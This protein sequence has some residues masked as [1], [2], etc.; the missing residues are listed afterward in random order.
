MHNSVVQ[1]SFS[2]G[3]WAALAVLCANWI[4]PISVHWLANVASTI[5]LLGAAI[6]VFRTFRER[7]L[8]AWISGWGVYLL[9]RVSSEA[10]FGKTPGIGVGL[11]Q[12]A[13]VTSV[14]LFSA[15]V[16]F[17]LE[18]RRFVAPTLAIGALFAALAA[19]RPLW[20]ADSAITLIVIQVLYRLMTFSV[21]GTIAVYSRGRRE[22]G[23]WLLAAM[24]VLLHM[25]V[26]T[27]THGFPA[28]DEVIEVLLGLAML[29]IVLDDSR[30]RARRL[31]ISSHITDVAARAPNV[32]AL[33]ES[34]LEEMRKLVRAR[35]ATFRLLQGNELA[36]V[37][38]IGASE[39]F[40]RSWSRPGSTSDF[41]C[42]MLQIGQPIV[43]RRNKIQGAIQQAFIEQHIVYAIVVPVRGNSS[44]IGTLSFGDSRVR[45]YR[46]DE[47]QFLSVLAKQL[48]IAIEN[49]HLIEQI[50]NSQREWAT[51]FDA[52]PDP[53]LVHDRE[54][55][56]MRANQALLERLAR[57][58]TA[59]IGR[60]C[61]EVLP[62]AAEWKQCP[63][64]DLAR[65]VADAPDPCFG[66]FSLV[67]TSRP[68]N[69]DAE[70]VGIIHIIR[71]TTESHAAEER[72]RSL[73]EQVQEG[74]FVSTPDGRVLEC[75]DA[76]VRMFG[77][78]S[79]EEILAAEIARRFYVN[80]EDRY[81]FLR[82]MSEQG[83]VRNFEVRLRK[84]DGTPITLL[85]NSFAVRS[86]TGEIECYRGVLLDISE[87]KRAEDE[88]RRHNREL[89][90]LNTI[91]V[92][93]NQSL[94]LDEI[95]N[96]A[97]RQ[98]I[99]L[100]SA[101]TG[102]IYALQA[103]RK[104]MRRCAT[105]GHRSQVA[106][107]LTELVVEE[108][109][110]EEVLR[111][112]TELVSQKDIGRIPERY[113]TFIEQEGLQSWAWVVMWAN[114]R[115]VGLLAISS[116]SAEHFSATDEKLVVAIARHLANSIEKVRLYDDVCRAYDDLRRTQEQLLQ[117]EKMSAIGQLISGVAHEL[118]NPLTAI[119]G[120]AQLLELEQ[121]DDK[122]R[123]YVDKV[124]KQA[125][126]T[127]RVVQNLL[128]FARQ[129]K[130]EKRVVQLQMV[131]EEAL[132]LRDYDLGLHNIEI[133]RDFSEVPPVFADAHQLEQVF[134]NIINNAVDAIL[135][136]CRGGTLRV[137][138]A[139]LG[140]HVLIRFHDSGPGIKE[141]NRVFDPFYTTKAVG[142]GTGLGLSICYGIVKEH[143]GDIRAHNHAGGG[144]VVEIVLPAAS[145]EQAQAA[146]MR[147]SIGTVPM[148][149]RILIID[150]EQAVVGFEREVL[151]GAGAEVI[152]ASGGE[153][154]ILQLREGAFDAIMVDSC[155]PGGW[156][157]MDIYD[158]LKKNRPGAEKR[159]VLTVSN[160]R[161]PSVQQFLEETKVDYLAKPFEVSEL[162]AVTRR[163]IQ[164]GKEL[165]T[166]ALP[167]L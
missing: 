147:P 163:I 160:L 102:A 116:R 125:Q 23:P 103:D 164:R 46:P 15:A 10:G 122:C 78:S 41:A 25:D 71:D 104:T 97:L 38:A 155:M 100:L 12:A 143:G 138:M 30:A 51:T 45:S 146:D 20:L 79:R 73:F 133:V 9:Y 166:T 69:G 127:Q 80:P 106:E 75:N 48:G 87:Q 44:V 83:Y 64:C 5:I 39:E 16:W 165:S 118:N 62:H 14:T 161:D 141:V 17:Y 144:A 111:T 114:D 65:N 6:L 113:R 145:A 88:L 1:V 49:L 112:R 54:F 94:D 124:F 32:D 89:E 82:R 19:V 35:V 108:N 86:A 115:C 154:A 77:Y 76:F 34:V 156:T 109:T 151:T 121:L 90:A 74:V 29:V 52:M 153:E 40:V 13:F 67:S 66:G 8:F 132:A 96:V 167:T 126:R 56:I 22:L 2:E 98:S 150:D 162:I 107:E 18:K 68:A 117:S 31:E 85:E 37:K 110:W 63:Y 157:G 134:L 27:R 26:G 55:R 131:T 139:S 152:C 129:H 43:L 33:L 105:F 60:T 70:G 42:E 95:L 91:A 101:D 119:L 58:A 120:Y 61:A 159:M 72:Y 47:L 28:F 4:T 135:E 158:W 50:L 130:A 136:V 36:L 99:E 92:V 142:K 137:S 123:D 128:S 11:T 57:T 148:R 3:W 149:G 53:I 81:R 140:R 24:F 93:A 7:Y 59:V 21:A 84:K